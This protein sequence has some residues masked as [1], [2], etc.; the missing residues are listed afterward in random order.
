MVSESIFTSS[1]TLFIGDGTKL[2]AWVEEDT[3]NA[4]S[5]LKRLKDMNGFLQYNN[6]SSISTFRV[7]KP[8][9]AAF[10]IVQRQYMINFK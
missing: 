6:P 4:N 9:D 10:S 3:I 8:P 2:P 1:I 5:A 7:I